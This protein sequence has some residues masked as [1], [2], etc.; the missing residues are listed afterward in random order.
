MLVDTSASMQRTGL[1]QQ[2]LDKANDV[3]AD[4]QPADRLAIVTFDRQPKTLL[5]FEQSRQLTP[6]QLKTTATKLLRE[7]SPSWHRTELGR[8][9]S[10]AGDLAVTFEPEDK[11]RVGIETE[12]SSAAM[13]P[14]S[15]D[16]AHLILISDLQTG[17]NLESLQVYAWPKQLRLDIRKVTPRERTNASAQILSATPDD[18]EAEQDRVRVRVTNTAD[19]TESRFRMRWSQGDRVE[20]VE[21]EDAPAAEL[22]VQVPPGESRVVR[23]PNPGPGVTSLVLEGDDHAF[24]NARYIV[25][26][27]PESLSL[28]YVGPMADDPRESLL[29]YL[30]RVP[31]SNERRSVSVESFAADKPGPVPDP[32]KVP[33]VVLAGGVSAEAVKGLRDYVTGG[34]RLLAVFSVAEGSSTAGS[35]GLSESLN[36]IAGGKLS[37]SEADVDDYVML[38]GIDFTHPLFGTMADPQFNDFS[39]IRF[40]SHRTL[41]NLN[42]AWQ[43]VAR[44]DDGDPAL[45]ECE[46]GQGRVFAL[47]AGWQPEASQLALST[48]F[49]PLVFSVFDSGRRVAGADRYVVGETIDFEPS[50]TATIT[51]PAGTA[52]EYRTADDLDG[53]EQPGIYAYRD[54]ET[55]HPFAVNLEES[56]SHTESLGDDEMERFGVVLGKN[57]TTEQALENQRQ[58]RD[59]ELESQQKLWQYLLVAALALL[60]LETLLGG[61][62][63]RT[64]TD[65]EVRYESA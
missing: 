21:T 54:A 37:A 18:A 58:L 60:G 12:E 32:D 4:L 56:E 52:I 9:I 31:L 45:I 3:L 29:Y 55:T 50:S 30:E 1:W 15:T 57:V 43:V 17:S 40:W 22:P 34:G 53:I 20:A 16:P 62:W 42:D 2:S 39:K 28:R 5:G 24:D 27:T 33:L 19:A 49:I 25:S 6:E 23:M 51:G 64:R 47:A 65:Q 36:A 41:S 13:G 35:S 63:S 38:T 8:A 14:S 26:P 7:T 11:T 61:W 59:R 10:F 48:K 46:V 44:F